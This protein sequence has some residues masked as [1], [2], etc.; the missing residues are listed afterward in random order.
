MEFYKND[1]SKNTDE[2]KRLIAEHPD[3]DIVVLA[4]EKQTAVI[5]RGC[6]VL[7]S[8]SVLRNF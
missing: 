5:I 3:Y 2:L 7:I 1:V 8:V 6:F 4:G